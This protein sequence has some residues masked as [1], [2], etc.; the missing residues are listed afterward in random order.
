VV[1]AGDTVIEFPVTLP[2]I[3][4]KVAL[5]EAVAVKVRESPKQIEDVGEEMVTLQA[6]AV[7]PARTTSRKRRYFILIWIVF[8]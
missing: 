1:V 2:G 3:H 4:T 6:I 7:L 5:P 8:V